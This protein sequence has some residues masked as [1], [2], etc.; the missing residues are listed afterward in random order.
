MTSLLGRYF[1]SSRI[2]GGYALA[3]VKLIN[4]AAIYAKIERRMSRIGTYISLLFI[5]AV[6]RDRTAT[7]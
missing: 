4:A 5:I 1:R 2:S 7:R 6:L 3:V